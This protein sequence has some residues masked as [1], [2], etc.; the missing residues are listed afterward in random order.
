MAT[1]LLTEINKAHSRCF[2]KA[3]I[4]RR[5]AFTG[6]FEADWF[7]ITEDVK[8]WGQIKTSVDITS[9]NKIKFNSAAITCANDDGKFNE[10]ISP[11]SYWFNYATRQ[12]S[13]V[14]I[15]YGYLK[16]ELN[17]G[18]WTNRDYTNESY[19]GKAYWGRDYWGASASSA[20]FVGILSGDQEVNDSNQVVLKIQPLTQVFVDYP[21][22]KIEG[23][24]STG[25]TASRFVEMLRDQ[26]DGSSNF[27]F[28]PF[29]GNTTSGFEIATTTNLYTNLNTSG[30]EDII[31]KNCWQ[32]I[33]KLC[34]A[35]N[36]I[37]QVKQGQIFSFGP[38]TA[39]STTSFSFY[40]I[41]T[42]KN[43]N[44]IT[45][46]KINSFGAKISNYYSRVQV[47]FLPEDT[48]TSYVV[49]ES[50]IE[51]A[52]GNAPWNYGYRTFSIDN[53]W[54]AN[55]AAAAAIALNLFNDLSALKREIEMTTSFIPHL[56]VLD[57]VDVTY[58]T[59]V[60]SG[61]TLWDINSWDTELT[62]DYAVG[63]NIQLS[64]EEF[65]V[66][67]ISID[68]DRLECGFVLRES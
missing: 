11:N 44:P 12:R 41:G 33:E 7:E 67:S 32:V 5:D 58:D 10:E 36:Y 8:R 53:N 28:R 46:K 3:Y 47:K 2:R 52:G 48:T 17:N 38:R 25:I 51:V 55:T 13:L 14:K 37:P 18:I 19:W 57:L 20:N 65:K 6:A 15:E 60:V 61:D 64:A 66:I 49:E 63:D 39:A 62:W 26:T 21:A 42:P 68:L 35:E 30:A 56:S 54:I 16:Q 34:Q 50:A 43:E 45:I 59:S 23:W 4:K 1:Q 24:T 40:G 27:V 22:Q 31:D 9:A 29:F